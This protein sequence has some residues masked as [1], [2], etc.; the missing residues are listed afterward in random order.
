MITGLL[1]KNATPLNVTYVWPPICWRLP[2]LTPPGEL[3]ADCVVGNS[4]RFGVPMGY[5]GPHAAFFATKEDYKRII[6]GR[7]IGVSVDA[8][9]KPA[10][11]MACKPAS[12]TYAAKKLPQIFARRRHCWLLWLV[13]MPFTMGLKG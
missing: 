11:R 7:I 2:C 4:Q 3:G 9:G 1:L 12:N 5:G 13:C 6:P 10:L 8:Q